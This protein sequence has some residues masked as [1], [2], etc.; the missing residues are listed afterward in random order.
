[1]AEKGGGMRAR[2]VVL[3]VCVA[4]AA[5]VALVSW[6]DSKTTTTW[7][8]PVH[9]AS[10]EALL[11]AEAAQTQVGVTVAY[12]GS[13]VEIDYPGGDVPVETGVC[14]DVVVR[15]F[16][17]LGTDLQVEVHDDMSDHFDEYPQKWGLPGPD[18]NI[19]H[20]RVPNLQTYFDRQG[21]AV[22]ITADASDYWPGDIVTWTVYGRPHIGI[23]STVLAR[24][25]NRYCIVHNFGRGTRVEDFLFDHKI[26]GHYRPL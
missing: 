5:V 6:A 25:G 17:E 13:Y 3:T 16:R 8:D 23:V 14:T 18:S 4:A 11:L 1:M 19:D 26:T 24:S 10:A 21:A 2:R 9:N 12:D 20:R 15:A 7:A 22:E